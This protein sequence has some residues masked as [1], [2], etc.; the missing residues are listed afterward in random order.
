[1]LDRKTE[2]GEGGLSSMETIGVFF[3]IAITDPGGGRI[4]ARDVTGSFEGELIGLLDNFVV[5]LEKRQNVRNSAVDVVDMMNAV[6][7]ARC[8]LE[9]GA[10]EL[11]KTRNVCGQHGNDTSRC[12]NSTRSG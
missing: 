12:G 3:A 8:L 6:Q 1:V 10:D 4:V 11:E 9:L 2:T 7:P 5:G